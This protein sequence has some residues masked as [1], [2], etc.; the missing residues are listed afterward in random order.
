MK[1]YLLILSLLLKQNF[2]GMRGKYLENKDNEPKKNKIALKLLNAFGLVFGFGV[3]I[4]M[5]YVLI[6]V[7]TLLCAIE[8][9][10]LDF[11]STIISGGQIMIIFFGIQS[12]LSNLFFARDN[13]FL[14]QLP[15]KPQ[16]IFAV[17]MTVIY[18]NELLITTL[19]MLPI[20]AG[21]ISGSLVGGVYIPFYF[22][23]LLPIIFLSAPIIPLVIVAV[24][25]FPLIKVVSYFK[26][27]TA[28]TLIA[29]ISAFVLF[30]AGYML[31]VPNI[32]KFFTIEGQATILTQQ[33]QNTISGVGRFVFYNHS[34]ASVALGVKPWLNLL[35]FVVTLVG[36]V[37]LILWLSSLLFAKAA[38]KSGESAVEKGNTTIKTTPISYKKTLFM[39]EFK[40]LFRDQ[41]FAFNSIMGSIMTPLII[42]VMT[43][44]GVTNQSFTGAGNAS[45]F[46]SQFSAGGFILF[47]TLML[48]C[49]MNYTASLAFT[50]DGNTFYTFRY[51]PIKLNDIIKAKLNLA[52][53]VSAVGLVL[54]GLVCIIFVK[55]KI[56]ILFPMLLTIGIYQYAF[57][58]LSLYRDLKRPNVTW[59]NA[60]EAIKRNFYPMIPMFIAMGIGVVCMLGAQFVV[61]IKI[62]SWAIGLIYWPAVIAGGIA[63]IFVVKYLFKKNAQEFFD[64][65]DCANN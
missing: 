31:L 48:M 55:L 23:L 46:V 5:L 40:T 25:S 63:I 32:D 4:G 18:L 41:N 9:L 15:V 49:G 47:Y 64:R 22:Y 26:K 19:F 56:Y 52:N 54:V 11:L 43:F 53:A 37:A 36:S 57:N 27:R 59:I 45:E 30:F 6:H 12:I 24:L 39:R 14:A 58:L 28:V 8:N 34:L 44:L 1:E 3:I 60:Y 2:R 62:G 17:K 33:M 13:E 35:I 65:I 16:V 51:L 29:S 7:M 20:I 61:L 38:S 21:F 42:A 50:R 10:S